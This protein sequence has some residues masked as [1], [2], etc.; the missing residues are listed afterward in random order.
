MKTHY[1]I[2]FV[3]EIFNSSSDTSDETEWISQDIKAQDKYIHLLD[4]LLWIVPSDL[5]RQLWLVV[6]RIV[7]LKVA[8]SAIKGE[9]GYW[10]IIE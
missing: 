7:P 5:T 3:E 4:G 8:K 2:W 6:E 9:K 10:I 1:L